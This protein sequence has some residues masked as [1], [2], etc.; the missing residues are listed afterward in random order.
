[1]A[2]EVLSD[3]PADV[4]VA[5]SQPVITWLVPFTNAGA[6]SCAKAEVVNN[7]MEHNRSER[8]ELKPPGFL[9]VL[10]YCE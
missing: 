5:L 8:I 6:L 3:V 7:K 4:P 9:L 2:K 1:M 10:V